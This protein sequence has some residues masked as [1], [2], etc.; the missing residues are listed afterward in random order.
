MIAERS[1]GNGCPIVLDRIL[2]FVIIYYYAVFSQENA[3]SDSRLQNIVT[4]VLV[5]PST[6]CGELLLY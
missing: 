4:K 3:D 5:H 2:Q 1:G 6:Q